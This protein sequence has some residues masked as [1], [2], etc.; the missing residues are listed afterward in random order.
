[1]NFPKVMNREWAQRVWRLN[2]PRWDMNFPKVMTREWAQR[3]AP[4]PRVV[5]EDDR[6]RNRRQE[7]RLG[8]ARMDERAMAVWRQQ[9]LHDVLDERA[10]FTQKRAERRAEQAAYR[11]DRRTRKQAVLFNMELE[12]ALTWSS[13]DE[14]WADDFIT[15]TE[16]KTSA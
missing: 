11:G 14:Q 6:C 13:D 10:F 7:H 8:I 12:G 5:T 16:S 1:M 15:M 3:L 2:R 4:P 9:F